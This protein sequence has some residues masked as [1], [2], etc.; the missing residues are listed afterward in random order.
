MVSAVPLKNSD[1]PKGFRL[2][3]LRC[4]ISS[5][6]GKKDLALFW[7]DRP[8]RAAGVFTK[9]LFSAAPVQYCQKKLKV[10]AAAQAVIINSGCANACTG[11]PG[12]ADTVWTAKEL[13]A[14]LGI[15]ATDVLVASTGVIGRHLPRP[16]LGRGIKQMAGLVRKGTPSTEDAVRAIMTT[17]TRPK[18]ARTTFA[19]G[20]TVYTVWGCA[21]GAGMIHPN[22]ATMLSVVL[23]DAPIS[24]Q[25]LQQ[26][27]SDV[28]KR[29]FNCVSVDGDTSTNDSLFL[30]S[31]GEGIRGDIRP[32]SSKGLNDFRSA[33]EEVCLSLSTQIAVDGEGATRLAWIFVQGA[34]TEKDAHQLAATVATSALFKTAL[35]GADPNW[36]RILAAIGRAGVS[37][38]PNKVDVSIGDV[39]VCRK[40]GKAHYSEKV[41]HS[42]LK[43]DHVTIVIDLHQGKAWS[44]Y[45][46]CDY[47][48]E[49]ITI[50]ADYTT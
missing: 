2:F 9:N 28:V 27:L 23:T 20:S 3:G 49:Y 17:D 38:D 46:T 10:S 16:A 41:V 8:A 1:L 35:H 7:S 12:M 18:A 44:R 13:A 30:L 6:P 31:N 33:L 29:T 36:G 19:V 47:S 43:K 25:P 40:G 24:A 39:L 50:N 11:K 34:R 14:A 26:S 15:K 22:M 45:A 5:K 4:G 32:L 42:I 48:K 21:K 37:F